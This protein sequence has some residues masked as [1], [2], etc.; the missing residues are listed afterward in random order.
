MILQHSQQS[1]TAHCS[2]TTRH[3]AESIPQT[4]RNQ[5]TPSQDS[6]QNTRNQG[7]PETRSTNEHKAPGTRFNQALEQ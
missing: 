1:T 3:R 5:F 7:M 2:H 6:V 4:Q